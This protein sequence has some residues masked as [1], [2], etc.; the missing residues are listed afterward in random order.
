MIQTPADIQLWNEF[1]SNFERGALG[2]IQKALEARIGAGTIALTI[3]AMESLSGYHAGQ[4]AD[5]STFEPFVRDYMGAYS[6][7]AGELYACVRN[8]LLHD[9]RLKTNGGRRFLITL[10]DGEFHL[11]PLLGDPSTTFLN[12]MALARDFLAAHADGLDQV[13]ALFAQVFDTAGTR[14]LVWGRAAERGH[15]GGGV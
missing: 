15:G 5:R 1:K 13:Q 3:V 6:A 12:S 10:G 9:Y 7:L 2:D 8:G 14:N 11:K 4:H